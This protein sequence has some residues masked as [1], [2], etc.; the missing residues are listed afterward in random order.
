MLEKHEKTL[1]GDDESSGLT[2]N[3]RQIMEERAEGKKQ[4]WAILLLVI[5]LVAE[6]I[7]NYL[8]RLHSLQ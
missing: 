2:H 8:G 4:R 6:R 1:Y 3:V 5:T 7:I